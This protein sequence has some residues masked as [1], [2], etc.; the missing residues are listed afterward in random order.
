M[1]GRPLST[2]EREMILSCLDFFEREKLHRQK[3]F[4][5][6][7]SCRTA[8]ALGISRATVFNV[9]KE[10]QDA[11][12]STSESEERRGKGACGRHCVELDNFMQN[13]IRREIHS[14]FSWK[15]FPTK[16]KIFHTCKGI[17]RI[18]LMCHG[19]LFGDC[20]ERWGS[21]TRNALDDVVCMN[22]PISLLSVMN[23]FAKSGR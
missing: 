11:G 6:D 19:Q 15:E 8:E 2:R 20:Y 5:N 10:T 14:F 7:P 9:K 22:A 21:N 12:R 17:S 18:F 1:S 13:C 4:G 16:D 3:F 23:F